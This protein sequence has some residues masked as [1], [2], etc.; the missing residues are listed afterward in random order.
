M[1]TGKGTQ[2]EHSNTQTERSDDD[3]SDDE[4]ASN[5]IKRTLQKQKA[6]MQG[7]TSEPNLAEKYEEFQ[8]NLELAE[9]EDS[10]E[11][12]KFQQEILIGTPTS[13]QNDTSVQQMLSRLDN[14]NETE[15]DIE[16]ENEEDAHNYKDIGERE[17]EV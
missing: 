11:Y 3:L 12:K 6:M 13:A 7:L 15:E 5:F 2:V 14:A 8:A 10:E 9:D 1:S 4:D 17:E 16:G